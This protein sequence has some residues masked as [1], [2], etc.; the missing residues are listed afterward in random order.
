MAARTEIQ[1]IVGLMQSDPM[2][3]QIGIVSDNMPSET[4]QI[5]EDPTSRHVAVSP[6]RLG[7]L[8]NIRTGIATISTS[9][10]AV[11]LYQAMVERL[12]DQAAKGRDGAIQLQSALDRC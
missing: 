7:E 10:G 4:F 8:P 6:F 2:G 5:F 3:I 9:P 11:S 1:R 12:W